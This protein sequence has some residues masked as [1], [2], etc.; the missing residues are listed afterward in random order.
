MRYI[1]PKTSP[2]SGVDTKGITIQSPAS[3]RI[4]SPHAARKKPHRKKPPPPPLPPPPPPLLL[5]LVLVLVLLVRL[6]SPTVPAVD[7]AA[8]AEDSD[9]ASES[10]PPVDCGGAKSAS[11]NC[12]ARTTLLT[13]RYRRNDTLTGVM[14]MWFNLFNS[15]VMGVRDS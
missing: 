10:L 1:S 2:L 15:L 8:I 14:V 4:G 5:V 13:G 11:V 3:T 7:E 6:P 9:A 12:R